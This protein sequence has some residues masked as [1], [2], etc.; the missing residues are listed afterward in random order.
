MKLSPDET[1]FW[2]NGFININLTLV[3]TWVIMLV[4]VVA[5]WLILIGL[6]LLLF[7]FRLSFLVF[8]LWRT[9]FTNILEL[10]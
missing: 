3:T 1:I 6:L 2:E 10:L 7:L 8:L 5:S 4:L 9:C